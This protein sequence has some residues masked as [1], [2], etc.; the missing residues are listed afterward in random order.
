QDSPLLGAC[1]PFAYGTF[2]VFEGRSSYT[3]TGADILNYFEELRT[4]LER[5]CYGQYFCEVANYFTRENL[6]ATA[7]MQ[8]LYQSLRALTKDS[9]PPG[10]VRSVYELRMIALNGEA[11]QVYA[12]VNCGAEGKTNYLSVRAGGLLCPDCRRLDPHGRELSDTT[13]YAMRFILSAPLQKLYTFVLSEEAQEELASV[14]KAYYRQYVDTEFQ[15]LS[16]L[17][18]L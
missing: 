1:Q 8:L 13:L 7:M 12:C 17:E 16:L 2:Q 5:I 14:M 3:I 10:L 18:G 15:S 9:L 4:D 11:P 6:P